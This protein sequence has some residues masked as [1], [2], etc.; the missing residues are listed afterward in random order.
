VSDTNLDPGESLFLSRSDVESVSTPRACFEGDEQGRLG[1]ET[2]SAADLYADV[3]ESMTGERSGRESPDERTVMT[4][5]GTPALDAAVWRDTL[6]DVESVRAVKDS[7]FSFPHHNEVLLT[8]RDRLSYV[9][10]GD[11]FFW[12]D[13]A[14][15]TEGFIGIL[16]WVAPTV[17]RAFCEACVDGRQLEPWVLEVYEKTSSALGTMISLPDTPLLSYEPA[18]LNALAEIGGQYGGP[19]REPYGP[20][21]DE[22]YDALADAVRPLAEMER[23][24]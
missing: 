12:Q 8:T 4:R 10:P 7:N 13:S 11:A 3:T 16:Y 24:L 23:E 17:F 1:P 19:P 5:G 14:L 20:L 18:V 15:G 22:A 6:L 9:S 21:S 2:L